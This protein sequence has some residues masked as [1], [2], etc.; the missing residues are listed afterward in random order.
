MLRT[1]HRAAA[2]GLDAAAF[3]HL[4]AHLDARRR[5]L[6]Q[7]LLHLFERFLLTPLA[8][9]ACSPYLVGGVR[10]S[11]AAFSIAR[12]WA[13][14][15]SFEPRPCAS[16]PMSPALRCVSL[17]RSDQGAFPA[18]RLTACRTRSG[19]LHFA[20]RVACDTVLSARHRSRI[21]RL[22]A[23]FL[24]LRAAVNSLDGLVSSLS[25]ASDR[26]AAFPLVVRVAVLHSSATQL[27]L[28]RL[29]IRLS[30]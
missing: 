19:R 15:L 5:Q 25:S 10:I 2:S 11:S 28:E 9:P 20:R 16:R 22:A 21:C 12:R 26:P 13:F 23:R 24:R 4:F 29:L 17:H 3:L 8:S 7:R 1:S 30:V 18:L 6:V 27:G 14:L